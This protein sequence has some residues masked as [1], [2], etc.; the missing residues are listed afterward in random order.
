MSRLKVRF[1][2]P[3]PRRSK[4]RFAPTIFLFEKQKN[5]VARFLAPPLRRKDRSRRLG[6][7]ALRAAFSFSFLRLLAS[8]AKG[9]GQGH[10]IGWR[11]LRAYLNFSFLILHCPSRAPRP[12]CERGS[13]PP[14]AGGGERKASEW[15]RSAFS[16]EHCERRKRRAPQQELSPE[17]TGG[18]A[19]L[20]HR[21]FLIPHCFNLTTV[22]PASPS[23]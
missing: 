12:P 16:S 5:V 7:F 3:A 1:L 11:A 10:S 14:A 23:P 20:P 19:S 4:V 18:L 15:P 2:S 13:E 8:L 21:V 22:T 17:V 9:Q 6:A